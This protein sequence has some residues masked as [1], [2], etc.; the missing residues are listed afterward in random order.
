ML[1]NVYT[2][3]PNDSD[4]LNMTYHIMVFDVVRHQRQDTL[5]IP[6]IVPF[7]K[8]SYKLL[9]IHLCLC[10][11]CESLQNAFQ[12]STASD[13]SQRLLACTCQRHP[14]EQS[15]SFSTSSKP[16][17]VKAPDVESA[18]RGDGLYL[19]P[20]VEMDECLP[21]HD[22]E[23]ENKFDAWVPAWRRHFD[24]CSEACCSG[25]MILVVC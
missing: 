20:H 9:R 4:P 11:L 19:D 3:S 14:L 24:N 15:N 25:S 12:L 22:L 17:G 10:C 23:V 18:G 5:H 2:A 6:S 8:L 16:P 13:K 1:T 7:V 21:G